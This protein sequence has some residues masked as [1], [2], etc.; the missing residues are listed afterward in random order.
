MKK[1]DF[2]RS[3]FLDSSNVEEI[4][5]WNATG[6]IDGVTTNQMIMLKD[7]VTP[8]QLKSTI[9]EISKIMKGK[10]VSIELSD[11]S[12]SAEE[13]VSEAKK[14]RELGDNIVIKIPLIPNDLKSLVV[15]KKLG[16]LKIPVNITAMMTYEQLMVATLATR[17]HPFPSFVSLFWARTMEDHE[18]YRTNKEFMKSFPLMGEPSSVNAHPAKITSAIM[19]FFEKGG[20]NNPKLIVGSIRNVGQIGEA[21][22]SGAN[23]VTITPAVLQ[24]KLFSQRTIETNADF[25]KAWKEL[26][27]KK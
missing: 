20:Y 6:I 4:K 26:K 11:S 3:I 5:K 17:N 7:G 12:A 15:I 27:A 21:F 22:A 9:K 1:I 23:I 2:N 13:M 25:D 24:A 10:P 14:Y 8:K 16:D 18:K 19:E